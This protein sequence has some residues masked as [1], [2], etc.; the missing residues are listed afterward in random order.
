MNLPR[1][2]IGLAAI[3]LLALAAPAAAQYMYLD[4]N[5]D[6]IHT[7]AD[8][9]NPVGP[10]TIEI[11]LDTDSNGDGSPAVCSVAG[12]PFTI[13][14]YA[15]GL[16]ATG[17]TVAWGTFTNRQ[18]A[19]GTH[20]LR[21]ETPTELI[22]E[23]YS[24]SYLPPGTYRLASLQM[25]VASGAPSIEII[26]TVSFPFPDQT[27]FGS[28][29]DSREFDHTLRL[30]VDWFDIDGLPFGT[31]GSPNSAP[32]LT[33]P[34][35]MVVSVGEPASQA[36]TATDADRQPVTF[37]KVSG[38][39]YA[40]VATI[41]IGS[42][43]AIGKIFLAPHI[44]DV[45]QATV[46]VSAADG[47]GA[48][49]KSFAVTVNSSP[50][51]L[52]ALAGPGSV[53]VVAGTTRRLRLSAVDP[54]G[55]TL[56]F[57]KIAGPDFTAV[58]TLASGAGAGA[59]S[60][61]LTPSLCDAGSAAVTIG[62]SDGVSTQPASIGLL[63][64][65][66]SKAIP[67]PPPYPVPSQTNAVASGDFNSDGN[68]DVVTASGVN[69]AMVSI[70][71]GGGDGTLAAA[72]SLTLAGREPSSIAAGDLN[73]D[74]HEDLA[75]AIISDPHV[76]ILIGQGDGSFVEGV[77]LA[78][79]SLPQKVKMA[80]LNGDGSLDLAVPNSAAASVSIF[81]GRGDGTFGARNDIEAG[82]GPIDAAVG[83]FNLD[84]LLDLAVP[85]FTS[86]SHT[87]TLLD[88]FGDGTFADSREIPFAGTPFEI[89]S[90]DWNWDGKLDLAVSDFL[91]LRMVILLG[92]GAGGFTRVGDFGQFEFSLPQSLAAEDLNADGN[93]D[94]V[95]GNLG[96][97][98]D[99]AYGVGDGTFL[100]VRHI[101]AAAMAVATGDL[102]DDGYPDAV[103]AY[104]NSLTVWLND[105]AGAGAAQ[106]RA[107]LKKSDRITRD[108][109]PAARTC[110]NVEPVA[111]SY[112]NTDL[113]FRSIT[114]TSEGTGSVSQIS[115]VELK[116]ADEKDTDRN[117][118]AEVPACFARADLAKLFDKVQGKQTLTA[119]LG[120]ALFD[121][122][123][124][125]AKV[126]IDVDGGH[127]SLAVTISPNPLNPQA[128]L[129]FSTAQDGFVRIRMFD[130]NGRLV[131]TLFDRPLV[132]AG[133][134]QVIIDGR[135]GNGEMLG[136]GIYFYQVEAL[137][138]TLRGRFTIL[139]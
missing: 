61:R 63:V 19:I 69:S 91:S 132:T 31:G 72:Q 50:N 29:C 42:G 124:F 86:T 38:P 5:G 25:D 66:P 120:G 74:G 55:Q 95:I 59:G 137:E 87:I 127:R 7:A 52:P 12:E 77:T 78:V 130:L 116:T 17:G 53:D 109:G 121:G 105:A 54:D 71:L 106:A 107:F 79:L 37:S 39:A 68:I 23:Y 43:S 139:K 138:G 4:S 85:N 67:S 81:L 35:D 92:D 11:W 134:H 102:N 30:G 76:V 48:D 27:S 60:L 100:P 70:S 131:R 123:R 47:I 24:F 82:G 114:L 89:V 57:S 93:L 113:N 83:D 104:G 94:L 135:G 16:R 119:R 21:G 64:L 10:T 65:V 49:Q 101:P 97:S 99:I 51:H 108:G 136:S 128:T 18:P 2:P 98:I 6:G 20:G 1:V 112:R 14:S 111:A 62:I 133:D 90:G 84:G 8:Q 26:S 115:A 110:I 73:E 125:C 122:R 129:R 22:D 80:D 44:G 32:V 88:G 126:D 13:N 28:S 56:A 41:E 117:G 33:Q 40:A 3:V 58:S 46:M 9:V 34:A 15:V 75:I 36:L 118:I 96:S 103:T 45:G